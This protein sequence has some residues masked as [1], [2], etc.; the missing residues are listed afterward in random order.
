DI[1]ESKDP[2]Q[3]GYYLDLYETLRNGGP[4]SVTP[5]SIRP[6]VAILEAAWNQFH[7]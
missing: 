4:L 7:M 1:K 2:G 6:Q 3:V 5:T